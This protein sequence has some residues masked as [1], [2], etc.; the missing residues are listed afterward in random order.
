VWAQR[1]AAVRA[2]GVEAV[3]D[4]TMER[5]FTPGFRAAHPQVVAH[6]R[7]RLS[8]TPAEG[9]IAACEAVAGLDGA[10][11][12]ASVR[13]PTLVIAGRH[14][15]GTTTAMSDAIAEAVPAQTTRVVLD[16]AHLSVLEQPQAFIEAV[17]A[18]LAGWPS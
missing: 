14:D 1:I 11:W 7:E 9:Y 13:C 5:F 2:G 17:Q 18:W 8:A 3:A 4:G 15:T 12:P 10:H 16:A 6:W